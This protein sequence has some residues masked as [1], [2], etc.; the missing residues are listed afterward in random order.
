M[1]PKLATKAIAEP[2]VQ[3]QESRRALRQLA[4]RVTLTGTADDKRQFHATLHDLS[5][6]GLRIRMEASIHCG[7]FVKLEADREADIEAIECRVTRIQTVEQAGQAQFEYGL[8]IS[9]SSREQGHR[10]FLH[11]CYGGTPRRSEV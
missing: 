10:W 6:R 11:F 7:Q 4:R 5:R 1:Q 3:L 2:R 8:Q 9:D